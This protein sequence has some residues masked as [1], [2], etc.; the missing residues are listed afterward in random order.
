MPPRKCG[1]RVARCVD[2]AGTG[3]GD[4]APDSVSGTDRTNRALRFLSRRPMLA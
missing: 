1:T 2:E 3:A 4:G